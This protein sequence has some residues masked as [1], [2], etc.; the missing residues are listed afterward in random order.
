MDIFCAIVPDRCPIRRSR[1][2]IVEGAWKTTSAILG[3]TLDNS[4]FE[5][6]AQI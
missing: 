1:K 6:H 5:R 2:R 3:L 4:R